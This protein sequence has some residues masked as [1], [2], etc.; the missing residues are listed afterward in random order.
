MT[1][2]HHLVLTACALMLTVGAANA[3]PCNTT[4]IGNGQQA[5]NRSAQADQREEHA[6]PSGRAATAEHRQSRAAK[7]PRAECG[8][9][10]ED[11]RPKSAVAS[12]SKDRKLRPRWLIRAAE[13]YG[14]RIALWSSP[15]SSSSR[16]S[17]R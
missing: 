2:K 3:G 9:I 14:T 8:A 17:T 13:T 4:G 6:Q 10:S 16:Q 1:A 5:A 15:P 12:P 7:R 11:D